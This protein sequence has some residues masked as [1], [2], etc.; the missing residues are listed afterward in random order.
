M[1]KCVDCHE[2]IT[3]KKDLV[4]APTLPF[5][6][7]TYHVKCFLKVR[8]RLE[9]LSLGRQPINDSGV[10]S[11]AVASIALTV[12][13][14]LNSYGYLLIAPLMIMPAIRLYSYLVYEKQLD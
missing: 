14:L 1:L 11:M 13:I 3:N 8:D 2:E 4:V 6:F 7:E 9:K 10:S 5:R 12:V